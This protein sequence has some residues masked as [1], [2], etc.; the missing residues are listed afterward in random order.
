MEHNSARV[1]L[2]KELEKITEAGEAPDIHPGE[3]H[4][5]RDAVS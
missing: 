2:T 4:A 1:N 5:P 3:Y